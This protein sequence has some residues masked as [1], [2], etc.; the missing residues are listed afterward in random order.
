MICFHAKLA[1][2]H[3]RTVSGQTV[4]NSPETPDR[5]CIAPARVM[6]AFC[7][8]HRSAVDCKAALVGPEVDEVTGAITGVRLDEVEI[9]QSFRLHA[10]DLLR[11]ARHVLAYWRAGITHLYKAE[12]LAVEL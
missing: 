1:S 3:G 6:S 11:P 5:V 8:T 7:P 9:G 4:D 2:V 12:T 10:A